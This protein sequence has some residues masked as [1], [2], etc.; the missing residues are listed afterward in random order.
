MCY[1]NL[2]SLEK[3]K[4]IQFD[5][6]CFKYISKSDTYYNLI[7]LFAHIRYN[8]TE[9]HN[10]LTIHIYNYIQNTGKTKKYITVL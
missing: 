2:C 8:P 4:N 3:L 7:S 1:F 6:F 9:Q 10:I 5:K